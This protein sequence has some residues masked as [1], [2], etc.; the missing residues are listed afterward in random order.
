[1]QLKEDIW[2]VLW[3]HLARTG[4]VLFYSLVDAL[5]TGE[6]EGSG[7]DYYVTIMGAVAEP[8][9]WRWGGFSLSREM[10]EDVFE[11][12]LTEINHMLYLINLE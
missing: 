10:F 7:V 12:R 2:G 4:L 8:F 3:L 11:E 6:V 5:S 1:M 9:Q